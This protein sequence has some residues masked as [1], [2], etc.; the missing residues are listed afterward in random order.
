MMIDT[1]L[2]QMALV[3]L[4]ARRAEVLR[5]IEE[6]EGRLGG[7]SK[8]GSTADPIAEAKPKHRISVRGEKAHRGSAKEAMGC[9]SCE[10]ECRGRCSVLNSEAEWPT[11]SP[12]SRRS[13][14]PHRDNWPL[15]GCG[16]PS[17][18][19]LVSV[20]G[21]SEIVRRCRRSGD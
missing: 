4:N 21:F 7:R 5:A 6:I 16:K 9:V 8:A 20:S 1:E 2:L 17:Q 15:A 13:S 3:G 14:T 19:S 12:P 18:F 11:P 10:E